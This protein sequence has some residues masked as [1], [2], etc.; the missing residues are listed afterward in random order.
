MFL[1]LPV[2][3]GER[4]AFSRA[5]YHREK[6]HV[7]G[8]VS[9]VV[10]SVLYVP[11]TPARVCARIHMHVCLCTPRVST[12]AHTGAYMNPSAH[13]GMCTHRLASTPREPGRTVCVFSCSPVTQGPSASPSPAQGQCPFSCP[14]WT[15]R[16]RSH[17]P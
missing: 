4:R 3:P 9:S 7:R 2:C 10:A 6:G 12:H 15:S 1:S 8:W 13:I 16:W 17:A 11:A 5:R 14:E